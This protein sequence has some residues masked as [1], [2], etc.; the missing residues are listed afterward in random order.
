[1]FIAINI[2]KKKVQWNNFVSKKPK[3]EE[4]IVAIYSLL[5]YEN[6]F[7]I[8]LFVWLQKRIIFAFGLYDI[9]IYERC[10]K[11]LV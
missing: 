10:R 11:V 1:M 3:I 6:I 8:L 9:Y 7:I 4:F 2:I 5:L